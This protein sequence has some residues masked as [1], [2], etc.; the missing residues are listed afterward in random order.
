[1]RTILSV[2]LVLVLAACSDDSDNNA[3]AD[4]PNVTVAN[5][6]V[7]HGLTCPPGT[8]SCR[9]AD[10]QD[11][12][13]QWV[14]SIG[15]PDLFLVQ[16]IIG[17]RIIDLLT[18]RVM[19]HCDSTYHIAAAE[20][21]AQNY[22]LTQHPVMQTNEDIL[23]GGLR[24]LWHTQIDHPTGVVDVFN[25]HL[26]AGIDLQPCGGSCPPACRAAGAVDTRQCQAVQIASLI[27]Q[28]AAP[29]SLRILAG[30][31]NA[32]PQSFVYNHLIEHDWIDVYLA[33]GNP[34]CEPATGIGC[35]SGRED[36][37]LSDMESPADGVRRRIDY[38]FLQLPP[39]RSTSCSYALDTHRDADG[40]GLATRIFADDPNPFTD[41]CGPLPNPICW[42]SDHEG[43]QADINCE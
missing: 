12:L 38:I 22:T 32:E 2:A 24:R 23:V 18:E 29:G 34:E 1:M 30:D 40:D 14:E 39:E 43:M 28:R 37:N 16:E 42:P 33:A 9:L 36:E 26:A 21:L 11:L 25:T 4:L 6:N 31:F 13:F 17:P 10:R 7:L 15:C 19:S 20:G 3:V 5:L 8:D 35:T 41:T 27:E